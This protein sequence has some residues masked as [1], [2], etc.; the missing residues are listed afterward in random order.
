MEV[1]GIFSVVSGQANQ[2]AVLWLG[3]ATSLIICL[4][5]LPVGLSVARR[6]GLLDQPDG[7]KTHKEPTPL[8]GGLCV[9][10]ALLAT[11]LIL[12]GYEVNLS[13]MIWLSIVLVVGLVDDFV[14]LSAVSRSIVH[15]IVVL[16]IWF[17]DG[18]SV[19]SIGSIFTP[20]E[21]VTFSVGVGL[22]FTGIAVIG[23]INAVNMIDGVDGLLGALVSVSLC[24]LLL[25]AVLTT[26]PGIVGNVFALT[27]VAILL[28]AIVGF[29]L[30]N[31]RL[32]GSASARVYMGDAGSTL[33]GFLL[34]YLLIDF[35]HGQNA[36]IGPVVAG[37]ILGVPLLDASAVILRRVLDRQSP[38][39]PGRD[40]M[41]HILLNRGF[42]VN[43]TVLLMVSLQVAMALFA[44]SLEQSGFIYSD[45]ILLWGFV[46]LVL[47]RAGLFKKSGSKSVYA[48]RPM[49]SQVH[50]V[51]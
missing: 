10:A 32:F 43:R 15:L 50:Q 12:V 26:E 48:K 37:W 22:F 19:Q 49:G 27:D 51:K 31:A 2:S 17:T 25:V 41:H 38:V 39:K 1:S 4:M 20:H 35:S 47:V 9:W 30:L 3:A 34:V 14:D 8:V 33:L 36:V 6:A 5:I 13:M 29:L 45:M 11:S 21:A 7:R 44:I 40:H 16:G 24:S 28:G 46:G 23:A 18:L 42:T